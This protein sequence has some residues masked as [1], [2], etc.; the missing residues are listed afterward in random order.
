[1]QAG[2]ERAIA[3][4]SARRIALMHLPMGPGSHRWGLTAAGY[5]TLMGLLM[6][7]LEPAYGERRAQPRM[8]TMI[9]PPAPIAARG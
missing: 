1:M 8:A 5:G 4:P 3:E 9:P 2:F 7:K 6:P